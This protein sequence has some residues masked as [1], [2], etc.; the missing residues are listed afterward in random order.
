L[1]YSE[2]V[3]SA[4]TYSISPNVGI[5]SA[6]L[7]ADNRTVTVVTGPR[8]WRT[9]Y[10]LNVSGA[11]DTAQTP[12]T[13]TTTNIVFEQ[14]SLIITGFFEDWKYETNNLDGAAWT[15]P[16]SGTFNDALWFVGPGI[17]GFEPGGAGSNTLRNAGLTLDVNGYQPATRWD[18]NTNQPTYYV[19]KV[20]AVSGPVPADTVFEM[21]H[22]IDD[23]GIGYV[24]G[25]EAFRMGFS[26]G[27]AVAFATYS[28]GAPVG[29]EATIQTNTLPLVAGN[30]LVAVEIHQQNATSSDVV[31]AARIVAVHRIVGPTMTITYS[32]PN[33]TV[34]W[35][36]AVGT[37]QQSTDL[38][39]WSNSANQA[40]GAARSAS[41]GNL[42]FRVVR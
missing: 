17:F 5:T 23:G 40:N 11:Q 31:F 10:T 34:S 25:A 27:Q 12:N 30:N 37:L 3:T 28:T 8:V 13:M 7:G 33:V 41:T 20:V 6:T 22:Y 35:L 32:A 1:Q 36:P 18:V 42:F 24:N 16:D 14:D 38:V 4:G 26:N 19:R 9:T 15:S 39:N 21:Q 29:G 2:P